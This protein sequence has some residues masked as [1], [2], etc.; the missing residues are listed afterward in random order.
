MRLLQITC[1]ALDKI[2]WSTNMAIKIYV[3][4]LPNELERRRLC[5][6]ELERAGLKFVFF[7]A[8]SGD[9]LSFSDFNKFYCANL[10][11]AKFKRPL[12]CNEIACALGHF[13]IWQRIV[14]SNEPVGL[15]LEDDAV[16][17]KNPSAFLNAVARCPERFEGVIIKLDGVP[18]K[19]VEVVGALASHDLLRSDLLPPRT[20]GYIIGR[21]AAKQLVNT[22]TPIGL[23]VDIYLKHYWE[24]KVPILTLGEKLVGENYRLASNIETHRKSQKPGSPFS[25]LLRNLKYQLQY[26]RG[27]LSH[28][29][30][31]NMTD[32]F[33]PLLYT[34]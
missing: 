21:R 13:Q 11:S 7:D 5:G 9:E 6:A 33:E 18:R 27:R 4:S 8:L 30:G 28:P 29:V 25:R 20:T 14:D 23:P 22:Y 12:S 2:Y 24:H 1:I 19:N 17:E 15:V 26:T 3:L 32:D 10:N 16:F 31:L 34:E